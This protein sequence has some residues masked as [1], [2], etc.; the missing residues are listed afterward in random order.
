MFPLKPPWEGHEDDE[1]LLAAVDAG[2]PAEEL[3]VGNGGVFGILKGFEFAVD[4]EGF[5]EALLVFVKIGGLADILVDDKISEET[6]EDREE[7]AGCVLGLDTVVGLL[8]QQA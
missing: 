4:D 2:V 5:I 8:L 6:S 7:V 1:D 3:P